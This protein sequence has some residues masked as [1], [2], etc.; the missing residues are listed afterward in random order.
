MFRPIKVVL[1]TL[2]NISDSPH[3]VEPHYPSIQQAHHKL[4]LILQATQHHR[5][6]SGLNNTI[7]N[8][9]TDK[10]IIANMYTPIN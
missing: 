9:I 1:G 8:I 7:D 3:L 4:V 5:D 6:R 10:H 2:I